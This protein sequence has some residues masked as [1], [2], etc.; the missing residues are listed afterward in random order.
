MTREE[1]KNIV[2]A[3]RG[4]YINCTITTQQIFDEWYM[5]LED[6]DYLTVSTNL[7]YHIKACKFPPTIAELR[8]NPNGFQNFIS[9]NYDMNKLQLALIGVL[10]V[11]GIEDVKVRKGEGITAEGESVSDKTLMMANESKK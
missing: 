9:R 7:Q 5:L 2:K 8:Q 6:M 3:M 11:N 10:D 4:A 1:F